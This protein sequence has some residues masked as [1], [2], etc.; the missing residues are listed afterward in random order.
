MTHI[1]RLPRSTVD[2]STHVLFGGFVARFEFW[3]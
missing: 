2:W 1:R 3:V